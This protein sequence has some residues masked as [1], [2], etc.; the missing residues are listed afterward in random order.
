MLSKLSIVL[1]LILILD[2]SL[3][4]YQFSSCYA[5]KQPGNVVLFSHFSIPY[6]SK[7]LTKVC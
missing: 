7:P 4:Y 6:V 5:G 3:N 2:F 1:I